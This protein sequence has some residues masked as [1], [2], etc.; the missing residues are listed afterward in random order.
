MLETLCCGRLTGVHSQ[1]AE[2]DA[3]R[4]EILRE[5]SPKL[6]RVA[7]FYDPDNPPGPSASRSR[8]RSCSGRIR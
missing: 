8:P 3:K 7:T 5:I 6:R 1:T 2:L 4:L